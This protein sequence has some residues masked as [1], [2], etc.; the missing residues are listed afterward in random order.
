M[1]TPTEIEL[2]GQPGMKPLAAPPEPASEVEQ[3]IR[4][5]I[6][7]G[8]NPTELY[9][10][11]RDERADRRVQAFARAK[12]E[13]IG[14][15]KRIVETKTGGGIT[16]SGKEFKFPY[17]DLCDILDQALSVL[18]RL[19][20]SHGFSLVVLADGKQ[21]QRCTLRHREGHAETCDVPYMP[22]MGGH[23][24][25]IQQIGSGLTYSERYAMLGALG[26]PTGGPPVDSATLKPITEEQVRSLNDLI[27]Q[28]GADRAKFLEFA[29]VK[30]LQEIKASQFDRLADMLNAKAKKA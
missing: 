21:Y 26:L 16:K 25:A 3:L 2:A 9:A 4:L 17:A 19:G 11:M 15:C 30:M 13:L 8:Q 14:Q 23:M 18:Q 27:I 7:A 29:G 24:N 6:A 28:V 10:I 12:W 22:D 20:F 5:A 1:T